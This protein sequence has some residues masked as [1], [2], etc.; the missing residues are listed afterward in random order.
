MPTAELLHKLTHKA[1]KLKK[2]WRRIFAVTCNILAVGLTGWCFHKYQADEDV[3]HVNYRRFHDDIDSIYP[4]LTLCFNNPYLKEKLNDIGEGI[5]ITTYV[6]FLEGRNW[7]ERMVHIDY[8]N[9][10][11]D[12]GDY[13]DLAE[14]TLENGSKSLNHGK[15]LYY[16]SQRSPLMKCYSFD[17]PYLPDT[18]IEFLAVRVKNSIFPFGFRPPQHD[19]DPERGRF[20]GGFQVTFNYPRQIFRSGFATKWRWNLLDPNGTLG[21]MQKKWVG[22]NF[23]VKNV[24]TLKRRSKSRLP[25]NDAWRN[26]DEEIIRKIMKTVNCRPPFWISHLDMPL[27]TKVI[28]FKTNLMIE[29]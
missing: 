5:N 7:D 12:L 4:S 19:F 2:T 8:D 23:E 16:V 3:S 13:L 11:I 20:F 6:S 25:C 10:T 28:Y 29:T 26:D 1:S 22:M 27:C 15:M 17:I 18:G 14:I 21:A 24:E 9:V